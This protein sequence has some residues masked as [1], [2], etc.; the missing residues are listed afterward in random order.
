MEKS[1]RASPWKASC[2]AHVYEALLIW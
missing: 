2:D 1:S